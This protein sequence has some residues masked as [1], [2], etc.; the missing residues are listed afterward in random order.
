MFNRSRRQT[1]QALL[2]GVPHLSVG[3]AG[4]PPSIAA[5]QHLR[6]LSFPLD[7]RGKLPEQIF[8]LP[9]EC[10]IRNLIHANIDI[11]D[12]ERIHSGA[13]GPSFRFLPDSDWRAAIPKNNRLGQALLHLMPA[14]VAQHSDKARAYRWTRFAAES[15]AGSFADM[16]T[17]LLSDTQD[18]RG[19]NSRS[20]KVR[21]NQV[22]DEMEKDDSLRSICFGL[23]E[24]ALG[25]CGDRVALGF[26]SVE[27]AVI[28]AR[29]QRGELSEKAL[30]DLGK[31]IFRQSIVDN[32]ADQ[33]S[34]V[35]RAGGDSDSAQ[36][37]GAAGA[38]ADDI[39][40]K[41]FYRLKVRER[42]IDLADNTGEM[43]YA[44][45]ARLTDADIDKAVQAVRI[46]ESGP[47]M[48][49]F[50]CD[51]GPWRAHLERTYPADFEHARRDIKEKMDE[52]SVPPPE[53][54]EQTYMATTRALMNELEKANKTVAE[55][56]TK[57]QFSAQQTETPKNSAKAKV[58]RLLERLHLS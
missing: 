26:A 9:P 11:S 5:F 38:Y 25:T 49:A 47:A 46:H 43:R 2:S 51:Y 58:S 48:Q 22:L 45:S 8:S 37:N 3:R 55:A 32:V 34:E 23:A 1:A 6:S 19:F 18:G 14:G 29:A 44:L 53:M 7:T 12:L 28:D 35:R 54:S 24:D 52:L 27:S 16:L 15:N 21:I 4:L 41:L 20:L 36:P 57:I 56:L 39:E 42:G 13:G 40:I 33:R 10:E 50:L 17:R 31:R 30:L